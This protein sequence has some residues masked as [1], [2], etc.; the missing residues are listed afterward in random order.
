VRQTMVYLFH[1]EG[2]PY[3]ML[4]SQKACFLAVPQMG[5]LQPLMAITLEITPAQLSTN[6]SCLAIPPQRSPLL[7]S[8]AYFMNLHAFCGPTLCVI[9]CL[10]FY[11][12]LGGANFSGGGVYEL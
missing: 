1:L 9:W 6:R 2:P 3:R 11:V 4:W 10:M 8:G 7:R 12:I 5:L